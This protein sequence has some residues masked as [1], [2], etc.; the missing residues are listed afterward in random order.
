MTR[1]TSIKSPNAVVFVQDGQAFSESDLDVNLYKLTQNF[2]Y[3]INLS[4]EQPK[5]IGS[6]ELSFRELNRQPDVQLNFSYI[7]E[8]SLENETQGKFFPS[9]YGTGLVTNNKLTDS[10]EW[11]PQST[12]GA[13]SFSDQGATFTITAGGYAKLKQNITYEVGKTYVSKMTMVDLEDLEQ[14]ICLPLTVQ[15]KH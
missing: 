15:I 6:Q 14:L 4:R 3:S 7:P 12:V 9:S 5:Q 1:G 13:V 10:S 2:D 11:S 8:P